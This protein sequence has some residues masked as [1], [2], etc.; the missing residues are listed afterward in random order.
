MPGSFFGFTAPALG[1]VIYLRSTFPLYWSMISVLGIFIT[2][3][4][5]VY[6]LFQL[7]GQ[8]FLLKIIFYFILQ[9]NIYQELK[10]M[11]LT[12]KESHRTIKI[13]FRMEFYLFIYFVLLSTKRNLSTK[14]GLF[15][16]SYFSPQTYPNIL[17]QYLRKYLLVF[18]SS[19]WM[20]NNYAKYFSLSW[21]FYKSRTMNGLNIQDN[22]NNRKTKISLQ[23]SYLAKILW[24]RESPWIQK[25]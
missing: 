20:A 21:N 12:D 23:K 11:L 8:F 19:Y 10:F 14:S 13:I 24:Q 17:F 5:I 2:T 25:A 15:R 1:S 9:S 18:F 4:L 6:R 22:S 16:I 7:A 3:G